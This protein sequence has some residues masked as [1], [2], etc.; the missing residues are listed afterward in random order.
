MRAVMN[1]K[2]LRLILA[3]LLVLL[4]PLAALAREVEYEN[5][6][7][8]VYVTPGEPTQVEF[9]GTI[10]GGFKKKLST[11]S[12][13]RK[14]SDL[15]IF[16]SD[17][18][19]NEGEVVIVRLND[20]RS[21]SIRVQRATSASPRD[22]IVKV[23]DPRGALL[24]TTSEE[25]APA[26]KERGFNYAPPSQISGFM[27]ELVLATEF[28]K[29]SI[30]GYRISDRFQG[31][32]VLD[33]GTISARIDR[34]FIGPNMWGYVIDA[35]NLLDTSQRLNPASFR[36]DGTRAVSMSNFEL[37]ARPLTVEQQISGKHRT[38]VY[39]ITRAKRLN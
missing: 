17:G 19:S 25:E 35:Q 6:E 39:V 15:V 14:D 32:T 28:G 23:S 7:I 29:K 8:E 18:I 16:A 12:L 33:D 4:S 1:N 27:R 21:Y 36:L 13:D 3:S 11:L 31:E 2:A 22:A 9:P 34:I 24:D 10:S 26:Y 30:P 20:G 37:A 38:K 5:Q